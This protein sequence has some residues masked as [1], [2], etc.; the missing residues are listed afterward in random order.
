[1]PKIDKNVEELAQ[2]RL[3]ELFTPTNMKDVVTLDR[4]GGII[5]IGGERADDSRLQNLHAEAEFFMESDLWKVI[6]ETAKR[7]AEIAMFE[8]GDSLDDMKKG[9]AI[10][11][12]LSAQQNAVNIFKQYQK[13]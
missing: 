8:A 12:T 3:K 5:Y 13:K 7:L 1:M 9:R 2:Q 10:L 6:N 4:K 11:Y